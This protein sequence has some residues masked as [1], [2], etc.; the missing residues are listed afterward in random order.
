[1]H[2]YLYNA[3]MLLCQYGVLSGPTHRMRDVARRAGV[4][5]SCIC[6][7]VFAVLG[8]VL[9]SVISFHGVITL[10]KNK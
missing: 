3:V 2:R 5:Q 9:R 1:M 10:K 7:V 6:T 8:S 4:H